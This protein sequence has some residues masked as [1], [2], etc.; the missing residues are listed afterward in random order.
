MSTSKKLSYAT[1]KNQINKVNKKE[2]IEGL[3]KINKKNEEL[4]RTFKYDN[5]ALSFRAGR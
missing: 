4:R 3:K 1:A 2:L 5:E